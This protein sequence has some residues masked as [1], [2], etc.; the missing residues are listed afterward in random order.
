[1]NRAIPLPVK[2]HCFVRNLFIAGASD[3]VI[4]ASIGEG[5]THK[6]HS[7]S[8]PSTGTRHCRCDWRWCA[9]EADLRATSRL[10]QRLRCGKSQAKFENETRDNDRLLVAGVVADCLVSADFSRTWRLPPSGLL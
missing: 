10:F 4:G 1:L 8:A 9:F 3:A 5:G 7:R 6:Q 2:F